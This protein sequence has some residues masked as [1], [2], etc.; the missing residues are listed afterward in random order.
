LD[1][2]L[3]HLDEFSVFGRSALFLILIVA[4]D[5]AITAIHSY[6]EWKGA[7]AP[8]WRNFG[9]IVGL[10][11][12]NLLG[13]LLFTVGLTL[14]LWV[15]GFVGIS[16]YFVSPGAAAGALGGLMGARL[17]DTLTSHIVPYG[18][19]YRP[20]PGLTSTPLYI[21]EALFIAF[22]FH[23]GLAAYPKSTGIGFAIG[24]LAFV[25]V[26][27]LLWLARF[28][29]PAYYRRAPWLRWHPIPQWASTSS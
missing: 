15:V 20:N 25:A 21:L 27:P 17:S 8:L 29:V 3:T 28:V 14:T 2:A 11:I 5:L 24:A 12:P 23:A 13:F 4:A 1:A 22:A 9:A 19:G 7:G 26:L 6:Q 10:Y 18:V 16:G